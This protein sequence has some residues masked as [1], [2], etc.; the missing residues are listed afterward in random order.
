MH[1]DLRQHQRLVDPVVDAV[2]RRVLLHVGR[3][4]DVDAIEAEASLVD[5]RRSEDVRVV[6]GA[7]LAV[8]GARVAEAG[9]RVACRLGC[10]AVSR[11]RSRRGAIARAER[12][13]VA[14]ELVDVDVCRPRA[15]EARSARRAR[16][17]RRRDEGQQVAHHGVGDPSA[18]GVAQDAAVE[19]EA[20]ALAQALVAQEEEG[21][22]LE[23]RAAEVHAELVAVERRLRLARGVEVVARVERLVAV[24]LERLAVVLFVPER[25]DVHHARRAQAYFALSVELPP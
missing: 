16:R 25:R 15:D 13:D 20:L 11:T 4:G 3:E 10:R 12:C 1:G 8:R 17:V 14:R 18:L 9:D 6:E 19:V 2:V 24:E 21:L 23:D 5:E 7:D 22:V